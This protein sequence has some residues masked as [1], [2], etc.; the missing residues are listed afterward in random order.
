MPIRFKTNAALVKIFYKMSSL[1]A[2][3]G[4]DWK[5]AAYRKA[6][7][8][9]EGLNNDVKTIY[10]EGGMKALEQIDGVGEGIA[11]KI[12]KY[13]KTG[14]IKLHGDLEKAAAKTPAKKAPKDRG[15]ARPYADVKKVAEK[16][17]R[18]L[19]NNAEA[20]L[21]RACLATN[22]VRASRIVVA[23]SIR[24]KKKTVHDIDLLA[25]TKNPSK[26]MEV[27]ASMPD[28]KRVLAKGLSKTMLVLESGSLKGGIQVDL[29]IIPAKSWGAALLYFTGDKLFNIKMRKRAIKLG[30]KL[31]EY[32]LFDRKSGE[33]VA[34]K[35]E[36]EIF[37]RLGI[38]YKK[39]ELRN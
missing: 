36:K 10:K 30:F 9:I 1:L 12:E 6:A 11:K 39:P 4:V 26:L 25:T 13:I 15:P 32:G 37:D 22:S 29:R 27:F 23:G 35:T 31:S 7:A 2:A 8:S 5:P 14:K 24:R 38:D 21:P 20:L 34:G 16:V 28:V 3:E 19:K 18:R 17:V 33:R